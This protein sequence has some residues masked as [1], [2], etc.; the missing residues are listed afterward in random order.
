MEIRQGYL[1][2]VPDRT[3]RVRIEGDQGWI[4]I[5]GKSINGCQPEYEYRIPKQDA[6]EILA[7][8]AEGFIIEKMR[9][10]IPIQG[11]VW[12]IDEFKGLNRGLVIAE[13][14][15]GSVN[16]MQKAL[17]NKPDWI[18]DDITSNFEYRNSNL[19]IQPFSHWSRESTA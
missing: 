5:K 18:G 16:E 15:V 3:V 6:T 8:L 19:A 2:T 14:E 1:S 9:H 10:K 7:N 13:I 12:E 4:T 11:F 17:K